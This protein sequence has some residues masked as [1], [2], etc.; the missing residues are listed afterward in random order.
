MV[1]YLLF[2]VDG[3]I[4][5]LI[6]SKCSH[7]EWKAYGVIA[8]Y[9]VLFFVFRLTSIFVN[10]RK[11]NSLS[12][13]GAILSLTWR[14]PN[15]VF[16]CQ[17][18]DPVV[19]KMET[20]RIVVI[21]TM[22]IAITALHVGFSDKFFKRIDETISRVKEDVDIDNDPYQRRKAEVL[23][24]LRKMID[25]ENFATYSTQMDK[26]LLDN[27]NPVGYPN[28][29]SAVKN[30]V[31]QIKNVIKKPFEFTQKQEFRSF[32]NYKFTRREEV[33]KIVNELM[34]Q[35]KN[36]KFAEP[37]SE[38]DFNLNISQKWEPFILAT[39][40]WLMLI[41]ICFAGIDIL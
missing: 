29:F 13:M 27:Q 18:N 38:S 12:L 21:M 24:G 39:F 17:M 33:A 15:L 30:K 16:A 35:K 14:L 22:I 23:S 2:L 34:F 3:C 5:W 32:R 7:D 40:R 20:T 31:S 26:I 1:K 11:V 25:Y 37:C 10:S 6:I 9:L 41:A 8:I 4:Y 19:I 28:Y 36:G